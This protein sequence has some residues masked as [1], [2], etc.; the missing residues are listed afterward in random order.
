MGRS[1]NF[2]APGRTEI[3][4]NHTDHQHGCVLAAASPERCRPSCRWIWWIPS[5]KEWNGF[6]V[7]ETVM[8]SPSDPRAVSGKC[9]EV[10]L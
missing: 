8:C 7:K 3:S 10:S 6:W 2:S 4:G 1:Y 5:K 9:E